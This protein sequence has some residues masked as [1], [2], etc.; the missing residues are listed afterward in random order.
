MKR[1]ISIALMAM[2]IMAGNMI[3]Q[4]KLEIVGGDTQ[5]WGKVKP[6]DSPLKA[7]VYLK[8]IG[9]PDTLKIYR[10]KPACGCTTAP[11]SKKEIA[12]GDSAELDVTLN[13]RNY[14]GN[15]HKTISIKTNDP[16]ARTKIFHLRTEVLRALTVSPRFINFRD[17]KPGEES[18][19]KVVVS[20]NSDK[21]IKVMELN[22]RPQNVKCD[23][24]KGT[25]IPPKG[26]LEI[27][28]SLV[29]EGTERIRGS[30]IFK[31]DHEDAPRVHI[32][33]YGSVRK[34]KPNRTLNK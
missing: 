27:N 13:V 20:N 16:N 34:P 31:T 21:E 6:K 30:I 2:F 1:L 22:I 11:L 24:K 18:S 25:V 19:A 26:K 7:K 14:S 12:P 15:V 17:A 29:P 32:Q 10:V 8:N 23:L 28:A 9:G 5:N 4:P 33:I 3:A